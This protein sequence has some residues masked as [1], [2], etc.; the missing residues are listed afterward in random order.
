MTKRNLSQKKSEKVLTN[1]IG[2]D[3]LHWSK[4]RRTSR[5]HHAA[6]RAWLI[7]DSAICR[8]FVR[9]VSSY[10]HFLF[11]EV[12]FYQLEGTAYQR[13]DQGDASAHDRL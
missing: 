1:R 9:E 2:R 3:I 8:L 5:S 10:A 11:L 7:Q 6:K 4:Q 13:R 12:L